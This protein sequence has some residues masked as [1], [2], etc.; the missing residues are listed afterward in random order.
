MT[1]ATIEK[2]LA[3]PTRDKISVCMAT[4]CYAKRRTGKRGKKSGCSAQF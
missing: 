4:G 1:L 2:C 3:G